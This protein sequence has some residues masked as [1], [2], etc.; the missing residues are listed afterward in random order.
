MIKTSPN[1]V[2]IFVHASILPAEVDRETQKWTIMGDGCI[3]IVQNTCNFILMYPKPSVHVFQ[4]NTGKTPPNKA[5]T[6]PEKYLT[7]F[8]RLGSW[9]LIQ[10]LMRDITE[11]VIFR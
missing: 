4:V 2:R 11:L 1:I 8:V 6:D 9:S 5:C 3:Q 10:P 7:S